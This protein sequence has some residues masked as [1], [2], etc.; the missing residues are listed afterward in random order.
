[1]KESIIYNLLFK[2]VKK[3]NKLALP[4]VR[5]IKAPLE[6]RGYWGTCEYS[7][8]DKCYHGRLVR[9]IVFMKGRNGWGWR[10]EEITDLINYEGETQWDLILDFEQA[11]EDYV[12]MLKELGKPV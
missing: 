4:R 7:E 12:S 6:F 5:K 11:V 2:S 9:R 1:M 8:E 3:A 10:P